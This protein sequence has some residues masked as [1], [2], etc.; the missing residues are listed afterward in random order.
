MGIFVILF[1]YLLFLKFVV[2]DANKK[3]RL[4]FSVF[5]GFGLWIVLALRSPYCGVDLLSGLDGSSNYHNMF[6]RACDYSL[7]EIIRGDLTFYSNMET[8]WLFFDDQFPDF[9][10][11]NSTC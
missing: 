10:C 6:V 3:N 5:A 2:K 9:Y 11:N 7:W 1:L 8:G 4:L